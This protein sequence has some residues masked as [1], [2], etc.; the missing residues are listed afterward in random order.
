MIKNVSSSQQQ[1]AREKND[2][3]S[4]CSNGLERAVFRF[5]SRKESNVMLLH[6]QKILSEQ[7]RVDVSSNHLPQTLCSFSRLGLTKKYVS[8]V[9]A[10]KK[11]AKHPAGNDLFCD[12]NNVL[13][14]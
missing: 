5:S 12:F 6:I 7:V 8:Y 14:L 4:L 2:S 11:S 9:V 1:E 3:I 13:N 10:D